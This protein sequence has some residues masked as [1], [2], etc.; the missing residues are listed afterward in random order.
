MYIYIYYRFKTYVFIYLE[1]ETCTL[2]G[3]FSWMT[4]P[5]ITWKMGGHHHFHPL[6]TFGCLGYQRYIYIQRTCLFFPVKLLLNLTNC[7]LQPWKPVFRQGHKLYDLV[8]QKKHLHYVK[9]GPPISGS[10]HICCTYNVPKTHMNNLGGGIFM[11]GIFREQ[12][13]RVQLLANVTH[14]NSLWY[15]PED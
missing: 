7:L 12:T 8:V 13:E 2:N 4:N 6:K 3:C 9:C 14:Q 10:S 5:I 1:P 11:G 15:T